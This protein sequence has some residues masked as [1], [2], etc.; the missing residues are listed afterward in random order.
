MTLL[1]LMA[2]RSLLARL[3][4]STPAGCWLLLPLLN[5]F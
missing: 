5:N 1:H 2:D 4:T 3:D